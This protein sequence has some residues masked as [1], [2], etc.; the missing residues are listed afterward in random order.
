MKVVFLNQSMIHKKGDYPE[1]FPAGHYKLKTSC[2]G[3][4]ALPDAFSCPVP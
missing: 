3:P 2:N 4:V 1:I